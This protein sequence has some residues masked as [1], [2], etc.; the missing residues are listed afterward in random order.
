M[1]PLWNQLVVA[2]THAGKPFLAYSDLHGSAYEDNFVATGYGAYLGLPLLRRFYREDMSEAEAVKLV[3]HVMEVLYYR[4]K[5]TINKISVAVIKADGVVVNAPEQLS[6]TWEIF[7]TP[8]NA[9][10]QTM[11][12]VTPPLRN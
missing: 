1:D 7:E 5:N 9:A 10:V 3:K 4:D 11:E 6:T 12:Y 2:G 8:E